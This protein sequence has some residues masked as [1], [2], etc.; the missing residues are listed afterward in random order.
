MW[1][2]FF[3]ALVALATAE[4]VKY[5]NYK[6]FRVTPQTPDQLEIVRNLEEIS[7]SVCITE[8]IDAY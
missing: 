6:V 3:V 5:D 7:D 2:L 8:F 4:Q 1:K